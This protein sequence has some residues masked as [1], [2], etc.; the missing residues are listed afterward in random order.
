MQLLFSLYSVHLFLAKIFLIGRDF[1]KDLMAAL[2][3]ISIIF[4]RIRSITGA[5]SIAQRLL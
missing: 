3:V 4:F 1:G 2:I 5:V